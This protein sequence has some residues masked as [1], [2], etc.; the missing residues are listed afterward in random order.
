[1]WDSEGLV[2][3]VDQIQ[4]HS[5][6]HQIEGFYKGVSLGSPVVCRAYDPAEVRVVYVQQEAEVECIF[7]GLEGWYVKG[8]EILFQEICITF[9]THVQSSTKH[10]RQSTHTTVDISK[11]G[12]GVL[13]VLIDDGKTEYNMKKVGKGLYRVTLDVNGFHCHK[14]DLFFNSEPVPGIIH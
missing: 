12:E 6:D 4:P 10:T 14:V 11:A 9:S 5:G 3:H 1:M 13:E 8:F 7:D 2:A